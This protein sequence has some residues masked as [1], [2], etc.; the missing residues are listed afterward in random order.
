LHILYGGGPLGKGIYALRSV[1]QGDNWSDPSPVFLAQDQSMLPFSPQLTVDADGELHGVWTVNRLDGNGDAVYYA[2]L[3]TD[4]SA[5]TEPILLA[6]AD[7]EDIPAVTSPAIVAHDGQLIVVYLQWSP[8][9][10]RM[11]VS[12]DGGLTWSDSVSFLAPTRGEYGPVTFAVDGDNALHVI[13][14]DR[15]RGLSLWHSVKKEGRWQ[16]PA[17]IV[18]PGESELY[19]IGHPLEFHPV[20]P[21][22][23]ISRGNIMIV[24]WALDPGHGD[25]GTWYAYRMLD[26]SELPV[27]PLPSL[28]QPALD[29]GASSASS[30]TVA[31]N[32]DQETTRSF[33]T[34][35]APADSAESS[36]SGL[37]LYS[38][39]PA[40]ALLIVVVV[41]QQLRDIRS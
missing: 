22:M 12:G 21:K 5:W 31:S 39:L 30:S 23:A 40:A 9:E 14:G 37:L 28:M 27:M 34:N 35:S 32:N 33:S 1:D 11:R 13:M 3:G 36:P 26:A 18:P 16:E 29:D 17:P 20:L 19:P 25:N 8:P 41:R 2:G 7:E 15:G 6:G 4:G 38:L 24:S 10:R